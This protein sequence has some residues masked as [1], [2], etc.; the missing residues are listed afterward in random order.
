MRA[1]AS[2]PSLRQGLR[3]PEDGPCWRGG[4]G[5][6]CRPVTRPRAD[7]CPCGAISPICWY[8]MIAGKGARG[9]PPSARRPPSSPFTVSSSS[10]PSHRPPSLADNTD[11]GPAMPAH[12]RPFPSAD[13]GL[14]A[15]T[16]RVS[17]P[18]RPGPCHWLRP[19]F[20]SPFSSPPA[21]AGPSSKG[22]VPEPRDQ[23]HAGVCTPRRTRAMSPLRASRT[24]EPPGTH[25]PGGLIRRLPGRRP[26][27]L[28][29]SRD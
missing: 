1:G 4:G 26:P 28:P 10:P 21:A 23:G 13:S 9:P 11:D 15:P 18:R 16:Q 14:P 24:A 3:G 2:R 22:Q 27:Q 19:G 5:A 7:G 29:P 20:G 25:L 17:F 6:T 8:R 12:A